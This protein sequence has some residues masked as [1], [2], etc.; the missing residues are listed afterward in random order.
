MKGLVIVE[1]PAKSKTI[2]KY[3]GPEYKVIASVGHICDLAT[4]G[5][6]GL[7]IDVDHDFATTYVIDKDKKKIVKELK[8]ESAKADRTYLATDPDREG[9]AISWH[10][11]RE[12]GLDLDDLNRV[13][14]NEI[15]KNAVTSA[16]ER[17]RK[18]DMDLVR[19]QESRR[20]LDRILG[21]KLSKLLNN[22]IKSKS[23][24]RVQSVALKLI[25]D[26]EKEIKAFKPEE[27]WTVSAQFEK[28]G[29]A[30]D[31]E[32]SKTGG[33]KPKIRSKEEADR[34]IAKCV[35]PF[36]VTDLDEKVRSKKPHLVFTT[37]TLQ[38]EASTKLGFAVKRTMRTAQSL[39]EGVSIN[40]DLNG[41]ITYMRTDST[42]LSPE[43]MAAA[44]EAI[45]ARYGKNYCGYYH[46]KN[47]SNAQDAHEGIRPTHLEFVPE[48]IKDSLT[49]DQYKLYRFIYYRTL[50]ALM[51][52]AKNNVIT[53]S[54][55][56]GDCEFLSSGHTQVFDGYLK[57]YA[58]YE[59][60]KD[61][62]LPDLVQNEKLD[63][64]KVSG[65]QHFT[66]PPVRYSEARL[67]KEMEKNGIG[68][69]STYADIIDKIQSRHY[70]ELTKQNESSKTKVFVP[71]EQGVLT[72]EKLDEYFGDMINVQY[73]AEMEDSLDRIAEGNLD[74]ISFERDFYNKLMPLLDNAY[75]NM[76]KKEPEKLGEVCPECGRELVIREGRFGKFIS[77]SGYPECKYHRPLEEKKKA[78]TVELDEVCPECGSKLLKRKSRY[79]NWFI[80]CS[81]FPK[82]RYI[83]NDESEPK[84]YY[85]RGKNKTK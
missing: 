19:S 53:A 56:S 43:F 13:E 29:I 41:L 74:N 57:V 40:G 55:T 32:L 42:R 21:F 59:S 48:E 69:P 3:L 50:A 12:L 30:F 76:E 75:K 4:S 9:E 67:V 60:N 20:V 11:A 80:G 46:Q 14:F 5:P 79:G 73:T 85:R 1:S 23:A 10:L 39:Y 63:A 44:K 27:F 58:E 37:S 71:T 84:K 18:I 28:D 16:F 31:A 45:T 6:S 24:G 52:D 34:I 81:N 61:V 65:E 49:S 72:S 22:K 35:N 33:K 26:R 83:R 54:L 78:E 62:V 66:E 51:A 38:Q 25:V 8:D 77:C 68:R 2:G 64:M 15:T 36:T 82:C 17:P 7:G 70:V 47:D